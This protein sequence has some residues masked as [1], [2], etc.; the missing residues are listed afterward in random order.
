VSEILDLTEAEA[1][2]IAEFSKTLSAKWDLLSEKLLFMS[3]MVNIST[4]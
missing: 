1:I 4:L 2:I 3:F